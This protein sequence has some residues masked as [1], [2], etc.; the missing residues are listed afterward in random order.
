MKSRIVSIYIYIFLHIVTMGLRKI[1]IVLIIKIIY[2]VTRWLFIWYYTRTCFIVRREPLKILYLI[3]N[4]CTHFAV[5]LIIIA[6][7][8]HSPKNIKINKSMFTEISHLYTRVNR[9]CL[10]NKFESKNAL[11]FVENRK[12]DYFFPPVSLIIHR[13]RYFKIRIDK[14]GT[15]ATT[16]MIN[17][18]VLC[19]YAYH[20]EKNCHN[21][22]HTYMT[23]RDLC[24]FKM[25]EFRERSVY[26][27]YNG[28]R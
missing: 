22:I 23:K 28:I 3:H 8:F 4:R 15:I 20:I 26:W 9:T 21:T 19:K 24:S 6:N 1:I 18:I 2:F 13:D 14:N 17:H 12:Y 10:L 11:S 7:K 25:C 27:N 5:W 16:T